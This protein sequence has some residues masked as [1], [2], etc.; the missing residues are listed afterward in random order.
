MADCIP[1]MPRRTFL[2]SSLACCACTLLVEQ[3]A[4][5]SGL[6]DSTISIENFSAAGQSE[7]TVAVTR[8]LK[9]DY[10]WR[11]QLANDAYIVTRRA[12]TETRFSGKYLNNHTDGLYRCICCGTALYDAKAKYDSG[13][14]WPSFWQPISRLNILEIQD[15]SLGMSRTAVSCNRCLAHLGHV[16][17]DGPRPTGLRYCMNSVSLN[18]TPRA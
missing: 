18:F 9:S 7:G 5:E 12:A 1:A 6:P 3:A 11:Q 8:I 2:L 10:E 14:G 17:N 15:D 16:F 4:A 13:T